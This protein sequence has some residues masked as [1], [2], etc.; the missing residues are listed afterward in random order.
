MP[1]ADFGELEVG[2]LNNIQQTSWFAMDEFG[3]ELDAVT[4]VDPAAN[5]IASFDYRDFET[6]VS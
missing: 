3:S 1:I 4:G 5:A 2:T 6:G